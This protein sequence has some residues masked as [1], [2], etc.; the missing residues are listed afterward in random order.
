MD[1]RVEELAAEAGVSVD[2]VRYYQGRGLVQPP[3]RQGRIAL[4]GPDH[5][6]RVRRIRT[7]QGKGLSL[8]TIGRLL[9]GDLDV[10]DEP[11]VA[12][13]A[14]SAARGSLTLAELADRTGIPLALLQSAEREG[15]LS[16]VAGGFS[17]ADADA[18]LAGLRLLELGLPLP[19]LL[20]L[21]RRH[22]E[23]IRAVA[24]EAVALFDTHIRRP[25]QDGDHDDEQA[26]AALVDAFTA[27]L[28]ATVHLV[29]HHFER[30]LLAVATEHIESVGGDAEL[31]A[32]AQASA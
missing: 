23:H 20:S 5:L 12:A 15:L 13:V 32:I 4:Y 30:T 17:A 18:A 27:L 9:S 14:G 29:A 6:D 25:L 8:E 28:P 19:E 16:P 22:H 31:A 21:A 3:R 1:L 24:E 7:L 10:I 2:T 26:A 11:L